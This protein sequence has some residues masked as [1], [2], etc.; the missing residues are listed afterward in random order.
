MI[1]LDSNTNTAK[2]ELYS[3]YTKTILTLFCNLIDSSDCSAPS[4][5]VFCFILGD[6]WFGCAE[7]A[8]EFIIGKNSPASGVFPQ[9]EK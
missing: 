9:S 3:F 1:S 6:S 2:P 4:C 8:A 5:N 7:V